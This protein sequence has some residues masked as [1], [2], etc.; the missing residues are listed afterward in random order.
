MIDVIIVGFALISIAAFTSSPK[1][2]ENYLYCDKE[3]CVEQ[4]EETTE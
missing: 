3:P 2:K 4:A 1:E